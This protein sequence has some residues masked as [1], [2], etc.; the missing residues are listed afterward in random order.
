[1]TSQDINIVQV[2]FTAVYQILATT[3]NTPVQ[4]SFPKPTE[5]VSQTD[6]IELKCVREGSLEWSKVLNHM[7]ETVPSVEVVSIDCIQ[8][9]LLWEK[10]CQHKE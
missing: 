5:W 7:R 6:P 3:A 10:Y 2:A 4:Q 9:E 1:M 8:N